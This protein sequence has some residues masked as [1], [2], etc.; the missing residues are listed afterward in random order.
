[1]SET[2]IRDDWRAQRSA[3]LKERL[4]AL[5]RK[6][7]T[8]PREFVAERL[9]L[10]KHEVDRLSCELGLKWNPDRDWLSYAGGFSVAL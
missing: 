10:S 4:K 3:H 7:P 5:N 9:G 1:M 6:E 2:H 8:L